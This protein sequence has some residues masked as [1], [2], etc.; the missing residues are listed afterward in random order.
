MSYPKARIRRFFRQHCQRS[1][2]SSALDLVYLDYCLFLQSLLKE[3][4][5]EAAKTGE[6]RVQ[7]EHVRSIQRKILA[8]F[9]G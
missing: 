4:N 5:I 1:L 9:K 6:R 7:P 2:E 8:Q 3:A